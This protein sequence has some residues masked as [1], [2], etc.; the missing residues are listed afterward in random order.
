MRGGFVL[1]M[2]DGDERPGRCLHTREYETVQRSYSD[3]ARG[4][5]EISGSRNLASPREAN[6]KRDERPGPPFLWRRLH[7]EAARGVPVVPGCNAHTRGR[8]GVA[9]LVILSGVP[10]PGGLL[11]RTRR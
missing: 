1:A 11:I 5:F 8:L 2:S 10:R 6:W 9:V 3:F 4:A 7:R